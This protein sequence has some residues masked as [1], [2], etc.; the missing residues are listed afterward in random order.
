MVRTYFLLVWAWTRAAAAYPVS[1]V[2]MIVLGFV[3]AAIDVGVILIIFANTTTLAGFSREEVLFLY[4]TAGWPSPSATRSSA[5]S[6]G[7]A[8]TSRPAP[9]TP[10]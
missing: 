3:I 2:M 5:T 1:F 10:S 7:S 8:G 6:T 9:S 4:G